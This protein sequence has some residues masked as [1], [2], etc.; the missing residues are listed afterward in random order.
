MSKDVEGRRRTSK[1]VE[2]CRRMSKD[3]E[4]IKNCMRR[5]EF[6]AFYGAGALVSMVGD[7]RSFGFR[8]YMGGSPPMS[9][10]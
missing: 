2:G 8:F 6:V 10:P 7:F 3:V 9:N 1:D 4:I 5:K